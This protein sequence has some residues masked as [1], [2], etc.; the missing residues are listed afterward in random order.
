MLREARDFFGAIRSL[1]QQ[2]LQLRR[3]TFR[4]A[5]PV[6]E[7]RGRANDQGRSV[8]AVQAQ[9]GESLHRFAETHLVGQDSAEILRGERR[10]PGDAGALIVAQLL[11][12]RPELAR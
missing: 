8:T 12:E 11:A 6:R 1:D 3:E 5:L 7:E 4:F 10:E 9:K 2:H